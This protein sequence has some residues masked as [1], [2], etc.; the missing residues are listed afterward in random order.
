[1]TLHH[2]TGCIRAGLA[3]QVK[4]QCGV[5]GIERR[6]EYVTRRL[7]R[8]L[9]GHSNLVVLGPPEELL[10][11]RIPIISFVIRCGD[12]FLHH[13]FVSAV[14]NDV[15]GIQ[16]RSGCMCAGPYAS[17]LLGLSAS[18]TEQLSELIHDAPHLKPG[19]VRLSLVYFN[20]NAALDFIIAALL[21]VAEHAWR[22]LPQYSFDPSTSNWKHRS[23]SNAS[24]LPLSLPPFSLYMQEAAGGGGDESEGTGEDG[25]KSEGT[26]PA[27]VVEGVPQRPYGVQCDDA[28]VLQHLPSYYASILEQ[29][30]EIYASC[31][32]LYTSDPPPQTERET[33]T[34]C[35]T[36]DGVPSPATAGMTFMADSVQ[37][38]GEGEGEGE[39]EALYGGGRRRYAWFV[40]PR[41]V[42]QAA[43]AG[44][45]GGW[46]SRLLSATTASCT[47]ASSSSSEAASDTGAAGAGAFI[48]PQDYWPS[49]CAREGGSE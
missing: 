19:F 18:D 25:S 34:G 12:K 31:H 42:L 3:F 30:H 22:L 16:T 5:P 33:E 38:E 48:R 20:S 35:N 47:A 27:S 40:F 24:A 4:A 26:A 6:E 29:S 36:A 11:S 32:A 28:S 44:G 14:I 15:Y 41:Q 8:E 43:Q 10:T 46:A 23:S 21:E 45:E 9:P 2:I 13:N 7:R 17:R 39:E 37:G 1:M 49:V